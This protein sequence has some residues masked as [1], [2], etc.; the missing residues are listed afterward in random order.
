V[1][2]VKQQRLNGR[3]GWTLRK[4]LKLLI[5]SVTA[6]SYAPIRIMS[7]VGLGISLVGLFYAFVVVANYLYGQ[8]AEGW[9]SLL[10]IVLII[11]GVQM[12][13][14]GILGEYL[15]R[16]LDEARGRPQYNIEVDSRHLVDSRRGAAEGADSHRAA[17]RL[18][19]DTAA[20]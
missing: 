13:M 1:R 5:D 11:G 16:A 17:I 14:L 6:F 19:L 12:S 8:P 15:W 3:S 4:K 9:S 10:F 7:L 18:D 20:P 2:Y